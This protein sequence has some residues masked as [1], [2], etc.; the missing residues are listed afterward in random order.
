MNL[1][2]MTA[3]A[4]QQ[5][6]IEKEERLRLTSHHDLQHEI[7]SSSQL[8]H[9]DN[10]LA[11]RN[12]P[13]TSPPPKAPTHQT[14]RHPRHPPQRTRRSNHRINRGRD[15][16]PV[17]RTIRKHPRRRMRSLPTRHDDAYGSPYAG[18]DSERGEKDSGGDKGA[19]SDGREEGFGE[20]GDE[21]EGN[22]GSGAGGAVRRV[23]REE[24]RE[25]EGRRT[26]RGLGGREHC[27]LGRGW[28][29]VPK[30]GF[31]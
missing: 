29:R 1:E 26:R 12:Q 6:R 28:R 24:W 11:G 8:K 14:N 31:A 5:A 15:A 17:R 22:E 13:P 30:S 16:S 9:D 25:E 10:L 2:T 27:S 7:H 3:A 21:E 20:S 19:E 4:R 23:V 18:A